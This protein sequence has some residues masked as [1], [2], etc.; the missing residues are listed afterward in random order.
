MG[1]SSPTRI[2]GFGE[3]ITQNYTNG[4]CWYLALALQF[5][6]G[7]T[8]IAL[9]A[10]GSIHHVGVELPN[11]DIVDIVGVWHR[12]NWLTEWEY[13]L[14]YLNDVHIDAVS[15]EDSY[16][17]LATQAFDEVMLESTASDDMSLGQVADEIVKILNKSGL[18]H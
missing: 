15:T 1:A 2:F 10:D 14:D 17:F 4:S 18:L 16:W 13:E 7:L 8:P 11:G 6:T 9:W 5:K 3:S 12:N